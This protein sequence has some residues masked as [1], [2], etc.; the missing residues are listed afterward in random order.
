MRRVAIWLAVWGHWLDVDYVNAL[1][2]AVAELAEEM[3]EGR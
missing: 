2:E 3:E 1:A